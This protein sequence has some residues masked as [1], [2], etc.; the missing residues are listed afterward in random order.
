MDE[1]PSALL[2]KP[3]LDVFGV[4]ANGDKTQIHKY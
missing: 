4:Y 1:K 2:P 3:A